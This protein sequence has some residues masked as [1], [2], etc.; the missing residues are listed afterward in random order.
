MNKVLV[1]LVG[2]VS[3]AACGV[4]AAQDAASIT[5]DTSA[6]DALPWYVSAKVG[7]A[8]PGTIEST[9]INIM[10]NG[11]GKSTFDAGFAGAF[12][13]GMNLTP[14]IRAELEIAHASNAGRSFEG[15]DAFGNPSSG[16][17]TGHATTTTVML[18]GAYDFTH[19][20]D[21]VPYLSAGVGVAHV[22]SNLTYDET[23]GF[24]MTD[25]TITG[26][27]T[28]LAARVGVGFNYELTDAISISAD[29]AALFGGE[30]TFTHTGVFSTSTVKSNFMAHALTAGI[31]AKF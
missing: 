25:G 31:K 27:N 18:V 3:M 28:V 23:V 22:N 12:A 20:G 11:T 15:T 29:Y 26:S 13:V 9:T 2:A 21:F 7:V 30:T 14:D 24:G 8:L 17:L 16:T 19:F 10:G 1:T 6:V 4:A 5:Y